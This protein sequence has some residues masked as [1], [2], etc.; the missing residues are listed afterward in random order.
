MAPDVREILSRNCEALREGLLNKWVPLARTG[1][2]TGLETV[3][4][5]FMGDSIGLELAYNTWYDMDICL[6]D[7]WVSPPKFQLKNQPPVP[8][9]RK[10]AHITVA[11]PAPVGASKKAKGRRVELIISW[12]RERYVPALTRSVAGRYRSPMRPGAKAKEARILT[13]TG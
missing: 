9:F 13:T 8:L 7:L 6:N 3:H 11:V 4:V 5:A 10:V 12:V 2:A 1:P